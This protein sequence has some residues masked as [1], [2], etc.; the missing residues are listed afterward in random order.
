MP[1]GRRDEAELVGLVQGGDAT[2][3]DE[4]VR[5]YM[6]RGYA[7]ALSIL[8]IPQ[9]AEDAVQTAFIRALERMDQLRPGSP[10]GPWFYSVLRSTALNLRRRES[11]RSHE[12]IPVSASGGSNPERELDRTLTRSRVLAALE[13][14]PEQ[15]RTAVILYDLEGYSHREVAEILGVA[16]GTSRA[17][18]HHGRKALR[19]HLGPV[20]ELETE[21]E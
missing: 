17:H 20:I 16:V 10:F 8:G 18:V 11:L 12:E 15:Q 14:L 9:D 2:A 6:D 4:L 21:E 3:F 7:V 13:E 19:D 1:T 5:R